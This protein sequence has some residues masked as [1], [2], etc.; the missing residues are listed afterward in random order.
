MKPTKQLRLLALFLT[1]LAQG[2]SYQSWYTG[3]QEQQRQNCQEKIGT[4][5]YRQCVDR[6]NHTS[7][8]QYKTQREQAIARPE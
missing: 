4:A 8:G 7:Y 5:E 6:V 3:L 2:C 1:L